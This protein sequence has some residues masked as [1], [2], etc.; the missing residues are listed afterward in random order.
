[1]RLSALS[2]ALLALPATATSNCSDAHS[3]LTVRTST[4]TFTGLIDS[5][6]PNTR[7]WRA[8]P[9]AEPP[10]ASRRW[11]RPQKLPPS[12]S[13]HRYS[14]KFPPSCPQFVTAV[15]S[16]WNLP[17]T[18]GNLIYNGAQNDTSGLV[19]E[20]TSEDCLY[21]AVWAPTKAPPKNGFPVQFFMTGG[22]FVI[23]GIELPWQIPTTWAERSQSSIIVTINYRVN[24]FG[25]PNARGLASNDQN[26]GIL[27]QRLALEWIR[28]NIA[29][30]G[31][32]P[33]RIM[34][35]GRSAGSISADIHAYAYHA[36]P[37][38]QSYYLESG[39]VSSGLAEDPT[40]S[41][42]SFVARHVG[43]AAPCGAACED[44]DGAAELDC[45]RLVSSAQISN[46]IGRYGDRAEQPALSFSVVPDDRIVFRD[47]EARAKAGK[48]ARRPSMISFTAN[49][50][51]SLAPWP[52]DNLTEGPWQ[53]A[54]TSR[55]I[56][57]VCTMLNATTRRNQLPDA[58]V[59]RFQ[60]AG[61][62]PN[63]NVYDWLGAYHNSETPMVFGTYGL[64]DHVANTTD[65]QV[66]VSQ[67]IQDH[68]MSFVKDPYNGPQKAFGWR[69]Q[70]VSEPNGGDMLRFGANGKAV[71]HIDGI[72]VDG[73]CAGVREYDPF[74]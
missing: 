44:E 71:Q 48:L 9:F 20:A 41:N 10:V 21:L 73:V 72:E 42:F 24:I 27:D 29:A 34:H 70:V 58:P 1:M 60:Y 68:I 50:F 30:F 46:F 49:E 69:P 62:F 28:D 52:K 38:A 23:G 54:V 13:I 33:T 12:P 39:T 59:F 64:L 53:A 2:L 4:G 66:E 17:L 56:A 57:A 74:P 40:H 35:W 8:I 5:E 45:M 22:G 15:E 11:L 16:M 61:V 55:D 63:L 3:K 25:F 65:F 19:G 51:S 37:I 14:T 47:Y 36:D 7:Q 32:N 26:L 67:S 43:C 6:Y 31:G 18:K